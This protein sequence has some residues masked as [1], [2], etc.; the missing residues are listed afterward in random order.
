MGLDGEVSCSRK[1]TAEMVSAVND[2][3]KIR[4]ARFAAPCGYIG[5]GRKNSDKVGKGGKKFAGRA[6]GGVAMFSL[7]EGSDFD[8]AG[9]KVQGV[10]L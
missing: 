7:P 6:E 8:A 2:S 9:V 3:I 5:Q 4:R 10:R 1:K